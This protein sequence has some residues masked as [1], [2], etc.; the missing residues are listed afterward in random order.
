M[1]PRKFA[2]TF[3]LRRPSSTSLELPLPSFL[4]LLLPTN[5]RQTKAET[6][7]V[8]WE[9]VGRSH[10]ISSINFAVVTTTTSMVSA[11]VKSGLGYAAPGQLEL[12]HLWPRI[13][14]AC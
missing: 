2:W 4:G 1:R 8:H 6:T 9:S 5:L 12:W 13:Q 10:R 14:S 7:Q 11:R 3:P